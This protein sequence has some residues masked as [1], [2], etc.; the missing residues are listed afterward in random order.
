MPFPLC[1]TIE[2]SSILVEIC[3]GKTLN[4]KHELETSQQKQ[5]LKLL[6]EN[7]STFA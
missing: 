2:S 6:W 5:L 4:I 1:Y 7:N 3:L